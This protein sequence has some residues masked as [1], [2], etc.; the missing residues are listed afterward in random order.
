MVAVSELLFIIVLLIG[1]WFESGMFI[2]Q[3]LCMKDFVPSL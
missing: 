2:P 1:L 3:G